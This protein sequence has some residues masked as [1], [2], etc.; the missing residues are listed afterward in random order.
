MLSNLFHFFLSRLT[1]SELVRQATEVVFVKFLILGLTFTVNILITRL[2]GPQGRGEVLLL[3]SVVLTI[4]QFGTFGIDYINNYGVAKKPERLNPFF[5][6]SFAFLTLFTPIIW[7]LIVL[8]I[9]SDWESDD[10][11]AFNLFLVSLS[12][13]LFLLGHFLGGLLLGLQNQRL[14]NIAEISGYIVQFLYLSTLVFLGSVEVLTVL[15]VFLVGPLTTVCFQ[16]YFLILKH[17]CSFA[18]PDFKEWRG[19]SRYAIQQYIEQ[20]LAF[21]IFRIDVFIVTA[22]LGINATGQYSIG[23]TW[24][25]LL[26]MVPQAIGRVL[27]P[28]LA[29]ANDYAYS[30]R[31]TKTSAQYTALLMFF[32]CS[33]IGVSS[34]IFIPLLYGDIF[35]PAIYGLIALLPGVWAWS[36]ESVVRKLIVAYNYKLSVLIGW[37]IALI[38]NLA[39]NFLLIPKLG[40]AG[41]GTALS[42]SMVFL[43]FYTLYLYRTH[44]DDPKVL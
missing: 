36:V 23:I 41:A 31:L 2:L 10:L 40:I 44:S 37:V 26:M 17:S 5:N 25:T 39:L 8:Y 7:V 42:V 18:R 13:P 34:F 22:L 29:G 33:V 3:L 21:I 16:I 1:A 11:N 20:F 30:R 38:I 15:L 12:I 28:T 43:L 32:V 24:A 4:V 35:T 27:F 14:Y 19:L 9:C 6:N